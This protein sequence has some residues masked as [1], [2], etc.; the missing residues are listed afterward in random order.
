[1]TLL[2]SSSPSRPLS[3]AFLKKLAPTE[4]DDIQ[5]NLLSKWKNEEKGVKK[6]EEQGLIQL[7]WQD[8]SNHVTQGKKS[9]EIKS[10]K[11]ILFCQM[12]CASARKTVQSYSPILR[13]VKS[14]ENKKVV[15]QPI[16]RKFGILSR[17]MK[18]IFWSHSTV[19]SY[20]KPTSISLVRAAK[21]NNPWL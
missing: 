12:R 2:P 4:I 14:W 8:V 7:R 20:T 3:S 18:M 16:F 9:D 19:P 6:K 21:R 15:V 17:G 13:Q 5:R 1:V 10:P 11:I